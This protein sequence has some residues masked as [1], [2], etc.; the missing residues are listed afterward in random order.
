MSWAPATVFKEHPGTFAKSE[1]AARLG[2]PA[3]DYKTVAVS[4]PGA[5]YGVWLLNQALDK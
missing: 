2:C 3:M 4:F 1:D 5:K